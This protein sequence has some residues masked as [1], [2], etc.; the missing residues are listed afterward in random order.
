MFYLLIGSCL[1]L[2]FSLLTFFTPIN[3]YP[4][5]FYYPWLVSKGLLPYRDF[6][7]HHGFLLYY[8]LAPLTFDKSLFYIKIF[9]F[10]I[11][12]I[13]LVFILLILKKITSKSGYVICGLF[14]ILV[15]YYLS[16][17]N[18]WYETVITC[19]YI[20][21]YFVFIQKKSNIQSYLLGFLISIVSFI[22][23]NAAIILLPVFYYLR[24]SKILVTFFMCWISALLFFYVNNSLPQLVNNLFL[25]NIK[26]GYY[27]RTHDH[28]VIEKSFLVFV[29]F[30]LV[31]LFGVRLK[32]KSL[33]I[34]FFFLISLTFLLNGFANTYLLPA[35][36][37]FTIYLG[38]VLKKSQNLYRYVLLGILLLFLIF[39][40]R[41]DKHQYTFFYNKPT[42]IEKVNKKII[43]ELKT[44][45]SPSTKLYIQGNHPEIYYLLDKTPVTYF[46]IIF[47]FTK[48]YF[49]AEK[50]IL[51]ELKRKNVD[52]IYM[53]PF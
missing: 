50:I 19:I 27:L 45:I 34:I 30:I 8:V 29:L 40:A 6:F 32:K 36:P 35:L 41:K 39:I 21:I 44:K 10:L 38:Y 2:F 20:I 12:G 47:P 52:Y 7:D 16:G 18:L 9:Y 42:Y 51:E 25:A 3:I 24:S 48:K 37:F 53:G 22:K 5:M 15:S 13:S 49:N 17:S 14:Y 33:Q 11:Q 1:F 26:I 23:P 4:E 43:S 46:T 28:I 31:L